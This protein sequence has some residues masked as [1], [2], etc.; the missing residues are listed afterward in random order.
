MRVLLTGHK[1]YIGSVLTPMLV[2]RGHEVHG[3][4]SNLFGRCAFGISSSNIPEVT[5][6]IRDAVLADLQ[7]FDA[8]M[9]LA[10]LSNDPLGYLNPQLT[11]ES[12]IG[13]PFILQSSP[14]PPESDASSFPPRAAITVPLATTCCARPLH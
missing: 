10:G 1:G 13:R 8:V 12:I 9:H 7:G 14:R 6:D 5:K 11:F 3:L 4:D 2:D